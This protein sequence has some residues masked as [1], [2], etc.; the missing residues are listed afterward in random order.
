V[1]PD[2]LDSPPL[3]PEETDEEAPVPAEEV[4]IEVE[5][6]TVIERFT[7]EE[8]FL[9]VEYVPAQLPDRRSVRPETAGV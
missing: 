1:F 2:T 8:H 7:V 3:I 4:T 6:A 5:V 9:R